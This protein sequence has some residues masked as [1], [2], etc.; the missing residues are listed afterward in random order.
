MKSIVLIALV[1]A[2][3]SVAADEPR[4]PTLEAA[5]AAIDLVQLTRVDELALNMF[6][7]VNQEKFA[8][9]KI[10]PVQLKCLGAVNLDTYTAFLANMLV[11]DLRFEEIKSALDFYSS[12]VGVKFQHMAYQYNWEQNPKEFPLK[13]EGPKLAMKY[14]EF[15]A[16]AS[17]RES[18]GGLRLASPVEYLTRPE[19][20]AEIRGL[21]L[22]QLLKCEGSR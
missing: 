15:S 7:D 1:T 20:I 12:P 9:K 21:Y 18:V 16:L 14:S 11:R 10:T 4:D 6:R 17:F 2:S 5:E 8:E 19:A 13:T 22:Q 3:L